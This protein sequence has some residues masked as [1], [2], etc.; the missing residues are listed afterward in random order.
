MT[1]KLKQLEEL[2]LFWAESITLRYTMSY[3]SNSITRLDDFF[4]IGVGGV[5]MSAI[6]QYLSGIGKSVSGSDRQFDASKKGDT[7]QKLEAE[8]ISCFKQDGSGISESTKVVVI[9]TAIEEDNIELVQAEELGALILHRAEMLKIISLSRKTIAISGTSGKS[10]TAGMLFHVLRESGWDPAFISGAG[11]V[12]LQQEGKLGNGCAGSGDWLIIEADESDGTLVQ[13]TPEI[14]VILNIDKDHKDMDELQEI[15]TTF[16]SNI[17]ERLI[18]NQSHRLAA[19]YSQAVEN[20]FGVEVGCGYSGEA[21]VQNGYAI[22]FTVSEQKFSMPVIGRHN[23]ENALAVIAVAHYLGISLEQIA[24]ALESYQGIYRRHQVLGDF[25][26][27]VL[28][29]DYAHN[30]SKIAASIQSAQSIAPRVIAWFQPHGF[31]PTKFLRDDLVKEISEVL[32]DGDEMWMSE[33]Y[34][35]G[36]TVIKDISAAD[37]IGDIVAQGKNARFVEN[38]DD[39]IE[40]YKSIKGKSDVL[41]LMGARD[42]SLADFAEDI[43]KGLQ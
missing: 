28:I 4:F 22:T 24:W 1:K 19:Q 30:P 12:S 31:G 27:T 29:D 23:M 42:P 2:F 34:Y 18:T 39:V 5:G 40:A 6:A 35:A 33:I 15:F 25:N 14:G 8:N 36:G 13:Y 16:K 26:G 3:D 41:L 32:R 21:F 38:R 37:L 17:T 7:Q 9:S 10:T 11:L 43:K 20:D